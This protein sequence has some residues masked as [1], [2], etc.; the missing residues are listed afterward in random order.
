MKARVMDALKATFRPEFLNRIDETI[1]FHGI[2][3]GTHYENCR[4][5]VEG[6]AQTAAGTG[7]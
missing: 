2:G 1:V 6:F 4:F 5:D 7:N 3:K